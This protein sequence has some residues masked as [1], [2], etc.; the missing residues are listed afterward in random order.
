MND[1]MIYKGYSAQITYDADDEILTRRIADISDGAG[2]QADT[3]EALPSAFHEAVEGYV[4]TCTKVGKGP[5]K[6]FRYADKVGI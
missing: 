1:A 3:V 6:V 4:D 2:F 5:L